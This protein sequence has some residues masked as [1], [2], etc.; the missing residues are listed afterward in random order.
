MFPGECVVEDL[1]IRYAVS[2]NH[3]KW[4]WSEVRICNEQPDLPDVLHNLT[5]TL[6]PG[7]RVG[8]LGRTGCGKSTLGEQPLRIVILDTEFFHLQLYHFSVLWKPLK[9]V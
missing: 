7:E 3:H 6:H 2:K 5:F 4:N 8:I 1:C 9:A